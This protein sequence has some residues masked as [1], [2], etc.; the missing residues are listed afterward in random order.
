MSEHEHRYEVAVLWTPNQGEGTTGYRAY[1]RD[2][3]ITAE[4]RPPIRGTSDPTYRGDASRWNPEQLLVA[5]LSQC[6][7]LWYLHLCS[8]SGVVVIAYEDHAEG[9]MVESGDGGGRFTE[10]I[11]RP[12]VTVAD[13]SMTDVAR[14]LHGGAH[15]LCYVANSVNFRVR[16]EP[17]VRADGDPT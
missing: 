17:A 1:S 15:E 14:E 5:S 13:A 6:H 10:V 12:L 16:H 2:N 4:G 3:E 7:L 11:L 8:T 9:L